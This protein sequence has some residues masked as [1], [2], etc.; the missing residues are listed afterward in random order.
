M[1]GCS[2]PGLAHE[3]LA[4]LSFGKGLALIKLFK[5][6]CCHLCLQHLALA[7]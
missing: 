3:P 6:F 5:A 1:L 7:F 4:T 2:S